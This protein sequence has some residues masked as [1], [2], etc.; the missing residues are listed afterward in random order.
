MTNDDDAP[1]LEFMYGLRAY[2]KVDCNKLAVE[3]YDKDQRQWQLST[4][5][6]GAMVQNVPG[7]TNT[8]LASSYIEEEE[9]VLQAQSLGYDMGDVA[10]AGTSCR[11]MPPVTL[12]SINE[13]KYKKN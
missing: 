11:L 10:D 1:S 13:K 6:E 12:T 5:S 3:V 2:N 4:S 7:P 8:T 9:K